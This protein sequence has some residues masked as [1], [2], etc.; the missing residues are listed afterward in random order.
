MFNLIIELLISWGSFSQKE[1]IKLVLI[2]VSAV[3]SVISVLLTRKYYSYDGMYISSLRTI[4]TSSKG[5]IVVSV[6]FGFWG[7]IA[8][9]IATT[10]SIKNIPKKCNQCG[11]VTKNQYSVCKKCLA[12]DNF[13]IVNADSIVINNKFK[14]PSILFTIITTLLFIIALFIK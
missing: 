11:Y 6:I 4:N 9:L 2:A 7:A 13:T 1:I 10:Q 8:C 12:K 5:W 3:L 14:M